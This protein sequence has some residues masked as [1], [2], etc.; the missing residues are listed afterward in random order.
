[1]SEMQQS[2]VPLK[3][4]FSDTAGLALP[5]F[6]APGPDGRLWGYNEAHGTGG[7]L[8]F[9]ESEDSDAP[10]PDQKQ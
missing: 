7:P 10:D 3:F 4:W 6:Y 1:M 9:S 2:K 8:V 5:I